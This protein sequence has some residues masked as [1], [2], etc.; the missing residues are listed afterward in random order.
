MQVPFPV[1]K[2]IQHPFRCSAQIFHLQRKVILSA[3][4]LSISFIHPPI[5]L[6]TTSSSLSQRCFTR[7]FLLCQ[8][9][10]LVLVVFSDSRSSTNPSSFSSFYQSAY[11]NLLSWRVCFETSAPEKHLFFIFAFLWVCYDLPAIEYAAMP[12]LQKKPLID[13][14]YACQSPRISFY[15]SNSQSTLSSVVRFLSPIPFRS[16][17]FPFVSAVSTLYSSR[18]PQCLL[19]NIGDTLFSNPSFILRPSFPHLPSAIFNFLSPRLRQCTLVL[20]Y[21]L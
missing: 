15:R 6:S 17:S 2:S 20:R 7:I 8:V 9:F 13:F 12:L 5:H 11:F 10:G 18:Y 1:V 16:V 3:F 4:S 19:Y 21:Y 14:V